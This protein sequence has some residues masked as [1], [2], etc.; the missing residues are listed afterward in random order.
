MKA[1]Q[2]VASSRYISFEWMNAYWQKLDIAPLVAAI[3]AFNKHKKF[4]K[5]KIQHK[6]LRVS[7]VIYSGN[8]ILLLC[9]QRL[10]WDLC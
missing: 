7:F 6:C 9:L 5:E 2:Q 4:N 8:R 3:I 10:A 1:R